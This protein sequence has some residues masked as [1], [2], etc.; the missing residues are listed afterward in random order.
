[1]VVTRTYSFIKA[2][3]HRPFKQFM[4]DVT[5]A[6]REGAK[7]P[8]KNMIADT[9]KLCGNSGFG[10]S[11]MDMSKHKQVKY[12]NDSDKVDR[13]I[14][15]FTFNE[16]E[17]LDGSYEVSMKKRRLRLTNP[18]HLSIAIYQ[19]AKLRML[20]FYYG[21][22]NYCID[23]R[24]FQL[25]EM[26]TDSLYMS[27]SADNA[28]PDLVKPELHQHYE[29]NKHKWFPRTDSKE[30]N[31]YDQKT[32]GIFKLEWKGDAIVALSSKNYICYLG[33]KKEKIEKKTDDEDEYYPDKV[34][35]KG[36]Q[37]ACGANSDILSPDA[38]ESVIR[39]R[40]I[41]QATNRGFRIINSTDFIDGRRV[42][43]DLKMVTYTQTKNGCG[44]YYS[45]R[46]VLADGIS[47]IPLDI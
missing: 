33:D 15:H 11:G 12:E 42:N 44:F 36:V 3:A 4:D 19:L 37:Q 20:Q 24:D 22:V 5:E 43:K 13:M 34:S 25:Q 30:I 28:F 8:S 46:K 38:F 1:M 35:A 21:C 16:L 26:D 14:E 45:K 7:D 9:M 18:I 6:R 17:E 32:P 41:L 27:V 47:T 29:E 10:R 40:V 2:N 31:E 39:N 23:R